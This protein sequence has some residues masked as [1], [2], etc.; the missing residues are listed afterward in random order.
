M[1]PLRLLTSSRKHAP[2]KKS[3]L[4]LVYATFV[5]VC[6]VWSSVRVLVVVWAN[7]LRA[8]FAFPIEST[9]SQSA[10]LLVMN[11]GWKN[12]PLHHEPV[13]FSACRF[14]R[15]WNA[16]ERSTKFPSS[17]RRRWN[18]APRTAQHFIFYFSFLCKCLVEKKKTKQIR[19]LC[20]I[21]TVRTRRRRC[22]A[23]GKSA[24]AGWPGYCFGFP[25]IHRKSRRNSRLLIEQFESL[26]PWRYDCRKIDCDVCDIR[27]K[28]KKKRSSGCRVY[29]A[30]FL[31][32]KIGR[33]QRLHRVRYEYFIIRLFTVV[34]KKF[35]FNNVIEG[36][37]ATAGQLRFF[38]DTL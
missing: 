26:P 5:C 1:I 28:N 17:I 35:F 36:L 32:F 12:L 21:F 33:V 30:V 38:H 4:T 34:V 29:S 10:I 18:F 15:L 37:R 7:D 27:Q 2:D 19:L 24:D 9:R 13:L 3:V 23:T 31:N 8:V 25:S 16:Y 20:W 14:D 22:T 6:R 11:Y